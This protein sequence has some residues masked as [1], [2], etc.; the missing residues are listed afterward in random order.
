[1]FLQ[2]LFLLMFRIFTHFSKNLT[3]F[4]IFLHFFYE[5]KTTRCGQTMRFRS[6]SNVAMVQ[7]S[8][9]YKVKF[10]M[11]WSSKP[12]PK[13]VCNV[14]NTNNTGSVSITHDLRY[15]SDCSLTVLDPVNLQFDKV[16]TEGLGKCF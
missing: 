9:N 2:F 5:P 15:N 8:L 13:P 3:Q 6:T 16:H 1:M 4:L 12:N 7:F 10:T 14:V 11:D